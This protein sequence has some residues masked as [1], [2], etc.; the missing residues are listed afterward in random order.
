MN[1]MNLESTKKYL[2]NQFY[3]ILEMQKKGIFPDNKFIFDFYN[4]V[5]IQCD[6]GDFET[7]SMYN[8]YSSFQNLSI[9]ES[10]NIL[11]NTTNIDFIILFNQQVDK[12]KYILFLLSKLF[13]YLDR[14][15]T[16]SKSILSLNEKAFNAYI[17]E[18]FIPLKDNLST[19]LTNFFLEINDKDSDQNGQQ[20][21]KVI[22]AMKELDEL[23]KPKLVK[24]NDEII[25]ENEN[26]NN[27]PSQKYELF[28]HWFNDHFIKDF[29]SFIE[30][31]LKE[32]QNVSITDYINE[33]LNFKYHPHILKK[34]FDTT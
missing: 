32:I 21:K 25:W 14:F 23:S 27:G 30:K 6:L 10:I 15:Y 20:I 24:K 11:K 28:D 12:I 31:I 9:K 17:N 13:M 16:K 5:L 3:Q 26:N 29:N 34:Y 8:L 2:T 19:A 1:K 18:F 22:K 4:A 33:I 7:E